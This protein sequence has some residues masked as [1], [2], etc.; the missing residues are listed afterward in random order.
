M[1]ILKAELLSRISQAKLHALPGTG[2]LSPL[3]SP[4]EVAAAIVEFIQS[5][6]SNVKAQGEEGLSVGSLSLKLSVSLVAGFIF[7][8]PAMHG[9]IDSK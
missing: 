4:V 2:H 3:E 9:L 6:K 1:P 8:L 5:L 7:M